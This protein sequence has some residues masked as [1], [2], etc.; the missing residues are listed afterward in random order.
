MILDCGWDR[1][2]LRHPMSTTDDMRRLIE[3]LPSDCHKRL[4]LHD[5]H[6]LSDEYNLGGLQLNARHPQPP[7][8]YSGFLSKSCHSVNEV[9]APR[10]KAVVSVTLS[11]IFDSVSKP[12]YRGAF[13]ARDLMSLTAADHVIALGGI[14]PE[15]LPHLERYEFEGFAALGY[16][17]SVADT[18]VLKERLIKIQPYICYSS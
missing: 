12:G 4:W 10:D 13:N 11:P 17:F 18:N 2:H 3:S 8:G 9:K 16:L 5:H 15:T 1:V 7:E 14:T 6:S